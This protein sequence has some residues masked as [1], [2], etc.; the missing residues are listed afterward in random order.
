MSL[1]R[2]STGKDSSKSESY[3]TRLESLRQEAQQLKSQVYLDSQ[4]QKNLNF[5]SDIARLQDQADSY[6][7]KI[8]RE[9]FKVAQLQDEIAAMNENIKNQRKTLSKSQISQK[10]ANEQMNR[11][12][13]A[14]ENNID[15]G[16]QK[17]NEILA[18]NKSIIDK[19]DALRRER[20]IYIQMS[21]ALEE[22]LEKRKEEMKDIVDKGAQAIKDREEI[23]KKIAEIK[24]EAEKEQEEFENEWR[25]LE[26]L[27]EK[28]KKSKEFITENERNLI[29]LEEE[30][31]ADLEVQIEMQTKKEKD[32]IQQQREKMQKYEEELQNL[33]ESTGIS[34]LEDVVKVYLDAEMQNLSLFNHVTELSAEMEQLDLQI[35]EI[36]GNVEKCKTHDTKADQDRRTTIKELELKVEKITLREEEFEKGYERTMKTMNSLVEGVR[37]LCNK[38]GMTEQEIEQRDEVEGLN[39]RNMIHYFSAAEAKINQLILDR[40]KSGNAKANSESLKKIEVEAPAVLELIEEDEFAQPMTTDEIRYKSLKRLNDEGDKRLRRK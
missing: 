3:R 23:R 5:H 7:R 40:E 9:R 32:M 12:I 4:E 1:K 28:D 18:Q 25:T 8:E 27:I 34:S 14:L 6:V 17:Y 19:I 21:K 36:K 11:K 38:L 39:E 29:G 24:Q 15:K 26:K 35:A 33:R 16:L 2:I 37:V 30:N 20:V 13:K 22:E 10:E 31:T